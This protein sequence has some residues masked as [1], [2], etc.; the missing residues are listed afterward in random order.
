MTTEWELAEY[1]TNH[2]AAVMGPIEAK[3]KKLP[4]AGKPLGPRL[5][6][7]VVDLGFAREPCQGGQ[8]EEARATGKG[9]T[10]P[11]KKPAS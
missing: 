2:Q 6:T 5:R 1:R 9:K 10:S 4:M 7:N 8:Q 3:A 11:I